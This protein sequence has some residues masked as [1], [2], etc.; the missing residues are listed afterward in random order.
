MASSRKSVVPIPLRRHSGSRL[1][2]PIAVRFCGSDA[3][4]RAWVPVR[5]TLATVADPR[6]FSGV[7][8]AE[9][10]G[11]DPSAAPRAVELA[12]LASKFGADVEVVG[13][14]PLAGG[15]TCSTHE[16]ELATAGGHRTVVLRRHGHESSVGL[17]RREYDHL[18]RLWAN[19]LPVAEPLLIDEEELFG[20]PTVVMS[21]LPGRPELDPDDPDDWA[22]QMGE[23]LARIHAVSPSSLGEPALD[24]VD[25]RLPDVWLPAVTAHPLGERAW[26]Q[27]RREPPAVTSP[28]VIHGDFQ[29]TNVL[30]TDGH[31][32]GLLDWTML[33][34]GPAGIDVGEARFETLLLLGP[35]AADRM[36]HA[37]EAALATTVADTDAWD[38]RA[39][40]VL[41][42]VVPLSSWASRYREMG[43][44]DLT[45][46]VLQD[47]RDRWI[48]THLRASA[49][50]G[51]G[52][53]QL[54]LWD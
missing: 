42:L 12:A 21:R 32:S 3:T 44:S 24:R 22:R 13:V 15:Q 40:L 53:D 43:R 7:P 47:R 54:G 6:S 30:W 28:V 18:E 35:D 23:T 49:A 29:S 39:A 26:E 10:V 19:G 41:G 11:F 50:H 4:D 38:L 8:D 34:Q 9:E 17:A 33:C 2:A 45:L 5:I 31:L 36:L 16:V 51:P 20:V 46:S 14:R 48:E 27:L 1:V 25:G 52:P 37:Y